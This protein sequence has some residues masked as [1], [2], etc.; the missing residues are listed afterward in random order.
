MIYGKYSTQDLYSLIFLLQSSS[1]LL[2]VQ[3]LIY[4]GDLL[5]LFMS[6]LGVKLLEHS[7]GFW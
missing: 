5:V 1:F 4:L 2:W 3:F 6:L 7:L